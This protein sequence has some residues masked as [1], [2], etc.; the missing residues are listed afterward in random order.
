MG[1]DESHEAHNDPDHAE[2]V[3]RAEAACARA[4]ERAKV[5]TYIS[6]ESWAKA[7]SNPIA[8]EAVAKVQARLR[9]EGRL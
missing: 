6:A 8:R 2:A 5:I 3:A 1:S 4:D 7:R 9:R